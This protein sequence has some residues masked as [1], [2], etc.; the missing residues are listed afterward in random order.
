MC[1]RKFGWWVG[2]AEVGDSGKVGVG[3]RF[4]F[5]FEHAAFGK[6]SKTVCSYHFDSPRFQRAGTDVPCS[7]HPRHV[8][9]Q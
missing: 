7:L 8:R 3:R 9:E 4:T 6:F 2:V 5:L 1:Y